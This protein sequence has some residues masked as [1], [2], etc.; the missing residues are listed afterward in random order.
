VAEL[1]KIKERITNQVDVLDIKDGDR[2]ELHSILFEKDRT[3]RKH[4][5]KNVRFE[6]CL[7]SQKQIKDIIFL[8]C[9]FEL[10]QFN[11]SMIEDCEFHQCI[12]DECVFYKAEI[13]NTYL[14]PLSFRFSSKWYRKWAN[15]NA[16]WYQSLFQN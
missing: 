3:R 1:P 9:S 12:F 7:F 10:C 8:N 2:V 14:D 6:R 4:R 16:W 13:E 5:I 15:V 11:G